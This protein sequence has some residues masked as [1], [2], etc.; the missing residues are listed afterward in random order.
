[1]LAQGAVVGAV[2]ACSARTAIIPVLPPAV[3]ASAAAMVGERSCRA[4][5]IGADAGALKAHRAPSFSFAAAVQSAE[6]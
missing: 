4:G 6:C 3:F 5:P 2:A 1:M